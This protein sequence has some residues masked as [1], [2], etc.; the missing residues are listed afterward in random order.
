MQFSA[1][2]T[3]AFAALV[4]A[5]PLEARKPTLAECCCC[6]GGP[7]V[8]CDA[9]QDCSPITEGKCSFTLCPF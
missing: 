6:N 2:I 9:D 4:A 8:G 7:S 1:V 5:S 3:I